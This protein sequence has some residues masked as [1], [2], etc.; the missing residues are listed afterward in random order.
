MKKQIFVFYSLGIR[1]NY[2][3]P[4][5]TVACAS[6]VLGGPAR[7]RKIKPDCKLNLC[8]ECFGSAQMCPSIRAKALSKAKIPAHR[9]EQHSESE[10]RDQSPSGSLYR[11]RKLMSRRHL[12][13]GEVFLMTAVQIF[14]FAIQDQ[15][16]PRGWLPPRCER[17]PQAH[18]STCHLPYVSLPALIVERQ[19]MRAQNYYLML[20]WTTK[21]DRGENS[22]IGRFH[23]DNGSSGGSEDPRRPGMDL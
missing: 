3:R 16:A 18:D 15:S 21:A 14:I 9:L 22:E 5:I 10:L 17:D 13:D 7:K 12:G 20:S 2:R 19:R 4:S 1:P 11:N 8:G 23:C 6:A